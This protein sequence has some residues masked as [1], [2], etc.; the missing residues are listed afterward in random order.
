MAEIQLPHK[1][2]L[3]DRKSLTMTGVTEIGRAHV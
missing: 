1:L 2:T 3:Q